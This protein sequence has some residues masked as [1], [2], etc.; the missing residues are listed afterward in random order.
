MSG[1]LPVPKETVDG[2]VSTQPETNI[3]FL[4]Q[5]DEHQYLIAKQTIETNLQ[6]QRELREHFGSLAIRDKRN[7]TIVIVLFLLLFFAFGFYALSQ[8][9]EALLADLLKVF[10]GAFGGVGIGYV[11]GARGGKNP[12]NPNQ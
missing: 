1:D 2:S 7:G 4:R 8:G 12:P 10:I 3:V 11:I 5:Q 6:N 9:N